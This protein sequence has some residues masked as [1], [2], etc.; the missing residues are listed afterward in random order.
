MVRTYT[1][2]RGVGGAAPARAGFMVGDTL[3]GMATQ[4]SSRRSAIRSLCL[5]LGLIVA[6]G[7]TAKHCHDHYAD[8][9]VA[10]GTVTRMHRGRYR[11][12]VEYTNAD[13]KRV[14]FRATSLSGYDV[15]ERVPVKY[16]AHGRAAE[17]MTADFGGM[18][19]PAVTLAVLGVLCVLSAV[20]MFAFDRR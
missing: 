20:A 7:A 10:E 9:D 8:A 6:G 5:G 18:Y 11:V 13:G 19:G 4:T 3:V 17:A 1:R 15:G 14:S 12:Q 16:F 2:A